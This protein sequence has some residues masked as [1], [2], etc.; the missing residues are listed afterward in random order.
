YVCDWVNDEQPYQMTVP[1][2]DLY[3]LPITYPLDDVNA[4]CDRRIEVR[5]WGTSVTEAF[6]R[7]REDGATNGRLLV[8]NLHPWLTGQAVRNPLHV[9]EETA[10]FDVLSN[11]RLDLGLGTG[12]PIEVEAFGVPREES[13]ARLRELYEMVQGL[14]TQTVYSHKGRYFQA[15]GISLSPR[16]L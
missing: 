7:L 16:P 8:L 10:T 1:A 11:G 13:R 12:S 2:G 9:A 15:D 3:A 5:R 14:W 6:D 4:L